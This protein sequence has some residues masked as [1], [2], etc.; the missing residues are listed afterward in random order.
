[1]GKGGQNKSFFSLYIFERFGSSANFKVRLV[2]H[3]QI[4]RTMHSFISI[5]VSVN[6]FPVV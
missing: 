1:M 4:N 5:L 6:D 2:T 3:Q